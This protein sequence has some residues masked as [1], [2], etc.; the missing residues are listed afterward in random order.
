MY[1]FIATVTI[2][3][4]IR[5]RGTPEG[6]TQYGFELRLPGQDPIIRWGHASEQLALEA[7]EQAIRGHYPYAERRQ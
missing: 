1:E 4:F 5:N 2:T 7:G 6:S 3:L